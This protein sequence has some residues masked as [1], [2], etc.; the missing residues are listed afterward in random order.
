MITREQL[1]QIIRVVQTIAVPV[2]LALVSRKLWGEPKE[3]V[4]KSLYLPLLTD[5]GFAP[6]TLPVTYRADATELETYERVSV[7][8]NTTVPGQKPEVTAVLLNWSRFPNV[9]LIT[10]LLCAPWL[11]DTVAEVFIWNN[12]PSKLRY[13]VCILF[14]FLCS[15]YETSQCVAFPGLEEHRVPE[16]EDTHTQCPV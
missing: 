5:I 14:L 7:I 1:R 13:E 11:Q 2:L 9:M 16:I 6:R 10:S 3:E 12:H 8:R 4:P 15:P